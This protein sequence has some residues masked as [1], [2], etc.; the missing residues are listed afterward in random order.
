MIR[1]IPRPSSTRASTLMPVPLPR[2]QRAPHARPRDGTLLH[3]R[4]AV[5]AV[6]AADAG[7]SQ[8][9]PVPHF[10]AAWRD[11][12]QVSTA[13]R[14]LTPAGS[15]PGR[16]IGRPE[17]AGGARR[18]RPMVA[19]QVALRAWALY[20]SWFYTDDY[21]SCSTRAPA[22]VRL[23]YLTRS[24]TTTSSCPWAARSWAG[25]V[26]P[27][28][29]NWAL[30]ATIMLAVQLLASVA[31]AWMLITVFG[32]RWGVLLPLG[33]YLSTA[34]TMP[35][36]MW[37]AAALN[38]LP[39][40]LAFFVAVGAWV[41]YL[42]PRR[43]RWLVADVAGPRH[44]P[45]AYVKTVLVVRRPG[46]RAVAYFTEG[47]P[48][49]PAAQPRSRGVTVAALRR[50]RRRGVHRSTT[51]P[52]C[53]RSTPRRP[54][55][56]PASSA[57]TMLGTAFG[58]GAVGGPW[59]WNNVQSAGRLRRPTRRGPCSA[60]WVLVVVLA[61][62]LALRRE[63]TGRAWLLLGGYLAAAYALCSRAGRRVGGAAIGPGVPLPDRRDAGGRARPRPGHDGR[64]GASGSS[65][66]R[67]RPPAPRDAAAGDWSRLL[68]AVVLVGGTTSS[69][70]LRAHLARRQSRERTTPRRSGTGS[71]TRGR[72]TSPTR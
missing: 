46:L 42:R 55:S 48:S 27:G 8:R 37:W 26:G 41:Q 62:G 22:A 1:N 34:V 28:N 18:R 49:A 71:A 47:R 51:S 9:P 30:T 40:Q 17:P 72:W 15:D 20:P 4:P 14:G 23:D 52:R 66:V 7:A 3:S 21:R 16:A 12:H 24:P 69:M 59:R 32:A 25:R 61:L 35:A 38:Q 60:A 6:T 10:A 31:C 68:V 58:S 5:R 11:M 39:L 29:A 44:R 33:V 65:A 57:D 45:A 2:T 54:G 13:E 70:Q 19:A 36:L 43:F 53:R 56:W 50:R 63:R 67:R 64:A